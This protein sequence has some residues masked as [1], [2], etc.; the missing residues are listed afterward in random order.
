VVAAAWHAGAVDRAPI[1]RADAIA[2]LRSRLFEPGSVADGFSPVELAD[3]GGDE[4][5][6]RFRWHGGRRIYVRLIPVGPE[7]LGAGPM[8]GKL[9]PA[10]VWADEVRA[11][12]VEDLE[13]G[14]VRQA[15]RRHEPDGVVLLERVLGTDRLRDV[16]YTSDVPLLQPVW[17]WSR[18]P[19]TTIRPPS[20][21]FVVLGGGEHDA[22][23]WE[24]DPLAGSWLA[25]AGL[26]VRIPR[27][28]IAEG[29]LLS[30]KQLC[31]DS[32]AAPSVGHAVTGW[33]PEL[34]G[35][36]RLELVG[37]VRDVPDEAVLRLVASVC[38]DAADAGAGEIVTDLSGPAIDG[39][40]FRNA[41][42]GRARRLDLRAP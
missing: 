35:V 33:H 23:D 41:P 29:R 27:R 22:R 2:A 10:D 19:R 36:A 18:R 4:L 12:L 7:D 13:T 30:W 42:E 1:T 6:L 38:H 16:Y 34:T 24:F 21:S 32:W 31:E 37:T 20:G 26:D 28:L 17:P 3:P 11:Q 39:A 14:L 9:V 8:T 25:E 15:V 5:R 40:G